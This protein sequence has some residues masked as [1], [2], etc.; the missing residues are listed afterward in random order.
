M[1]LKF[2]CVYWALLVV[3]VLLGGYAIACY[4]GFVV[5]RIS[6]EALIGITIVIGSIGIA[7]HVLEEKKP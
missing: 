7:T 5:P 4:Y 2:I 1:K 3:S 6:A